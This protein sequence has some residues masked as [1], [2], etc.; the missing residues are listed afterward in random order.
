MIPRALPCQGPWR[1]IP[2]MTSNNVRRNV[3]VNVTTSNLH[4]NLMVGVGVKM[5]QEKSHDLIHT[6]CKTNNVI[7][8]WL[9][10]M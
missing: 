4:D 3:P 6:S 5:G 9:S 2:P 1:F 7:C 8:L 10:M